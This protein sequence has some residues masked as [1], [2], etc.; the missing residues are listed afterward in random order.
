[1]SDSRFYARRKP[2]RQKTL[3]NGIVRIHGLDLHALPDFSF[4]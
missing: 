1:M 4:R 3:I 2:E